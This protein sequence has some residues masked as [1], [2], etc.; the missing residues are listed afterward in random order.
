MIFG[1]DKIELD[2]LRDANVRLQERINALLGDVRFLQE[3][4]AVGHKEFQKQLQDLQAWARELSQDLQQEKETRSHLEGIATQFSEV[5]A[6]A[7]KAEQQLKILQ[8]FAPVQIMLRQTVDGEQQS[9]EL[10]DSHDECVMAV[11]RA[12]GADPDKNNVS[13]VFK[14]LPVAVLR[15][16][17]T[18]YSAGE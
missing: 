10:F 13:V 9:S 8:K 17:L 6:R 18:I 16:G 7:E 1:K 14:L 11:R 5:S 4:K 15:N 3:S 2:G 12:V